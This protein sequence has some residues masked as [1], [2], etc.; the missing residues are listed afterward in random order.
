MTVPA[1]GVD[2][3]ALPWDDAVSGPVIDELSEG[4][5]RRGRITS[6]K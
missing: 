4:A 2:S 6:E 3:C 5:C 1:A